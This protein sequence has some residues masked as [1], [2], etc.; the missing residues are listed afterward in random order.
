MKKTIAAVTIM[1]VIIFFGYPYVL[2][3]IVEY[4]LKKAGIL[5]TSTKFERAPYQ[6]IL[7]N[8]TLYLPLNQE[9]LAVVEVPDFIVKY[10]LSSMLNDR[11]DQIIIPVA[12]IKVPFY[13][14]KPQKSTINERINYKALD[15]LRPDNAL[16]IKQVNIWVKD[17]KH[18]ISGLIQGEIKLTGLHEQGNAYITSEW[19]V[20]PL[21]YKKIFLIN[22]AIFKVNGKVFAQKKQTEV[23]ITG[24]V[25]SAKIRNFAID[26]FNFKSKIKLSNQSEKITT[27]FVLEKLYIDV[28][29]WH[30]N[31]LFVH[32]SFEYHN[33]LYGKIHFVDHS[34]F[35]N[36]MIQFDDSQYQLEINSVDFREN[37]V[38]FDNVVPGLNTDSM[39][40]NGQLKIKGKGDLKQY[41][42]TNISVSGDNFQIEGQRLHVDNFDLDFNIN[43]L[44]PLM[45]SSGTLNADKINYYFSLNNTKI[46]FTVNQLVGK[47]TLN[48]KNLKTGFAG[49]NI[50]LKNQYY[51]LKDYENDI[52]LDVNQVQLNQLAKIINVDGLTGQCRI[53]GN[54]QLVILPNTIK[55]KNGRLSKQSQY[56]LISYKPEKTPNSIVSNSSVNAV[57]QYL[58][59]IVVDELDIFLSTS[60]NGTKLTANILGKN[61]NMYEGIPI[62]LNLNI[63][64][65]LQAILT[66]IFIGDDTVRKV[67]S[68]E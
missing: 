25:T 50:N 6:L 23:D 7:K 36:G 9:E 38:L 21:K 53:G 32:G 24:Q 39:L 8:I 2:S 33:G 42:K 55:V 61:P 30:K 51:T 66:S 40:V 43:Q 60:S 1:L 45:I 44:Y 19:N 13:F 49:G 17:P 59:H 27:N 37:K 4:N 15:A 35:F 65:P 16:W 28:K 22:E 5:T 20:K 54:L 62:K 34:S 26:N 47:T 10:S 41:P 63:N 58:N 12:N 48:I 31:P 46:N 57:M 52:A 3:F 11:L 14:I 64:G 18:N 56:C 67:Q 29:R 68:L